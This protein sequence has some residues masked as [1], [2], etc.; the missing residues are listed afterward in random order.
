MKL[1]HY[2]DGV[3]LPCFTRDSSGPII[4]KIIVEKV[5]E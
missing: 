4:W 3:N 5:Q 2:V 1:W